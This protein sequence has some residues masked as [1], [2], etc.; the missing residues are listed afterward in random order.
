MV[1]RSELNQKLAAVADNELSV[2]DFGE[3]LDSASWNMHRHAS[4][5]V[6]DVVSSIDRLFAE[7][8]HGDFDEVQLREEIVALLPPEPVKYII[9]SA[10]RC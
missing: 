1:S 9:A 5:F 8:D 4:R 3:W 10:R 6:Q 2:F 7:Y